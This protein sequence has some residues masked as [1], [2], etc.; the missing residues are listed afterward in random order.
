MRI[1]FLSRSQT[2]RRI[3]TALRTRFS[4]WLEKRIPPSEQVRLDHRRI[5]IFPTANGG[6]FLGVSLVLF[7]AGV[8]YQN[9]LILALCFLLI[10]IFLNGIFATY[11]NLSG[12]VFES[13]GVLAVGV[14]ETLNFDFRVS[15]PRSAGQ[16][17]HL[18]LA[19]QAAVCTYYGVQEQRVSLPYVA[20]RRG[21]CKPGRFYLES[22]YPLGLIRAWS[23]IDLGFAGLVYP[24]AI[25]CPVQTSFDEAVGDKTSG[26]REGVD[27]FS[28]LRD[29][30]YGDS[31][32]HIDWKTFS[33]CG[34]LHTKQYLGQSGESNWI[35]WDE[36]R[37]MSDERRL[38]AMTYRILAHCES[39]EPFGLRLPNLEIS[40]YMGKAHIYRTLKAVALF[41]LED[42]KTD[43]A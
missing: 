2:Y 9:N 33:K 36:W 8:N 29:Y 5:F 43:S 19:G 23:W 4:A 28:E 32:K 38:S 42:G 40:P 39:R 21:W 10:S 12:L 25:D 14:G 13:E 11:R 15:G 31:P 41:R 17:L 3:E 6:L 30:Q 20:T 27:D 7:L 37:L 35:D 18:K 26:W 22:C 1:V 34:E 16:A 24:R